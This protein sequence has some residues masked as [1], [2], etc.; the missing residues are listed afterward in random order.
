MGRGRLYVAILDSADSI[1][2]TVKSAKVGG[3]LLFIKNVAPSVPA[4]GTK[5]NYANCLNYGLLLR[6]LAWW[7]NHRLSI[8]N[9]G[10]QGIQM[11]QRNLKTLTMGAVVAA[12]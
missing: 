2:F 5:K 4:Y 3:S 7:L 11:L 1:A 12:A 8:F 9:S 10:E 6:M